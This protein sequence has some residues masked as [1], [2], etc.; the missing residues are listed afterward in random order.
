MGKLG[1]VTGCMPSDAA[2]TRR[3]T[4]KTGWWRYIERE[5]GVCLHIFLQIARGGGVSAQ[6]R[7]HAGTSRSDLSCSLHIRVSTCFS[8]SYLF[9]LLI[10]DQTLI[11]LLSY[12]SALGL[13]CSTWDLSVRWLLL[14]QSTALVLTSSSW[15]HGHTTFHG[16]QRA[17]T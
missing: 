13:C 17:G 8:F 5:K 3:K 10:F 7:A 2:C 4:S 9:H 14:L 16:C 15:S 1:P 11:L 12:L 6:Q